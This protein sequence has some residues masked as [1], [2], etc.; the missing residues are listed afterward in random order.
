VIGPEVARA[1]GPAARR[2]AAAGCPDPV[3]DAQALAEASARLGRRAAAQR[4]EELVERRTRLEP[5]AYLLGRQVFRGLELKVDPRVLVPRPHT[6]AL[7]EVG[8][9][10]PRGARV[11]DLCTGSGAVALALANERPD[12]RVSGA[13]LSSDALAVAR[14]NGDRLGIEVDWL[15]SDLMLE[16]SGPWD[17]VLA[18]VPYIAGRD[19]PELAREM[20]A[21]EPPL[22][23]RGGEDGLD[24]VRRLLA[25]A[26]EVPFLAVEVGD[27]H[28]GIVAGLFCRAGWSE[29]TTRRDFTGIERVV[30]GT[31]DVL[32]EPASLARL[33][34]R[35]RWRGVYPERVGEPD[36]A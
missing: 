34:R 7:V 20:I 16:A 28:A 33:A 23:F 9:A 32:G 22:A 24:I 1:L 2:L 10:V 29:V 30:A 8:L 4:F 17:A 27:E 25:Q 31:R 6:E 11:L 21:Y 36:A 5:L 13:D 18:N 12:L 14:E 15:L 3:A 26:R 19:E 35:M